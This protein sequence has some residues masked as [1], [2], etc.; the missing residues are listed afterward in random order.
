MTEVINI[1]DG[2][3]NRGEY[4]EVDYWLIKLVFVSIKEFCNN[5]LHIKPFFQKFSFL[6]FERFLNASM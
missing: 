5:L 2:I 3:F 6:F 4:F 1:F